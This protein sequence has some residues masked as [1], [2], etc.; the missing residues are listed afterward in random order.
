M[1]PS[2]S[3]EWFPNQLQPANPSILLRLAKSVLL[4][5]CRFH[6]VCTRPG[7]REGGKKTQPFNRF[8][9]HP[10]TLETGYKLKYVKK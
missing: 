10:V 7:K 8:A 2:N 6:T 1:S 9:S 5:G 3:V 4:W